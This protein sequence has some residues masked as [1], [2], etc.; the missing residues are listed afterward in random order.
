MPLELRSRWRKTSEVLKLETIPQLLQNPLAMILLVIECE[1]YYQDGS[2]Y[3][4]RCMCYAASMT[5]QKCDHMPAHV[6]GRGFGLVSIH[7][8]GS[9][10]RVVPRI[11][12]WV[13]KELLLAA[14]LILRRILPS[15][16]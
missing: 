2:P 16:V 6:E 1:K 14:W 5:M 15:A 12:A 3:L 9:H 10:F 8:W 13:H 11:Q 4:L 7:M